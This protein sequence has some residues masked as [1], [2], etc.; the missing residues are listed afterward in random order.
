MNIHPPTRFG[1]AVLV[2][3][4]PITTAK[5]EY[6]EPRTFQ[7]AISGKDKE[8]WMMAMTEELHS[9]D[10]NHTWKLGDKPLK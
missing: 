7:E 4:A 2:S 6:H 5:L 9:L 10:K 1:H 8:K 3:Y